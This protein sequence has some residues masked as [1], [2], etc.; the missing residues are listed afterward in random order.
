MGK[1]H[2][3]ALCH[4]VVGEQPP[5]VIYG[6]AVVAPCVCLV[7]VGVGVLDVD[8]PLTYDG[9]QALH[10]ALLHVEGCLYGDVPLLG[11]RLGKLLYEHAAQTWLAAAEGDTAA[12]GH[13]VEVVY[14]H[15][16]EKVA[17]GDLAPHPFR[18]EARGVEAVVATERAAVECH[19]RGDALAVDSQS[20]A[21]YPYYRCALHRAISI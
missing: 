6:T 17:S 15:L 13:E 11:H 16:V 20:M 10:M 9:Q 8:D 7:D 5:Q 3:D 2:D 4:A 18:Y 21:S 19:E 12:S 14:A 1:A